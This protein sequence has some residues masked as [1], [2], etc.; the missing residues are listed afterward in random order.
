ME[1]SIVLAQ[2]LGLVFILIG[3]FTDIEKTRLQGVLQFKVFR[4]RL[5]LAITFIYVV[6]TIIISKYL[7]G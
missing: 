4:V 6:C 1:L 7:I 3:V 2:M 5:T